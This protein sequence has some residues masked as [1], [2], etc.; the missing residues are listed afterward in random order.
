VRKSKGKDKE[1]AK[2][3]ELEAE[4]EGEA[5]E[6]LDEEEIY[7]R[8]FERA[9]KQRFHYE[10]EANLEESPHQASSILFFLFPF[11]FFLFPFSFLF[12]SYS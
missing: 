3:T 12:F 10:D 2:L 1:K 5:E 4:E 9:I 6:G 7:E 8:D 11:S